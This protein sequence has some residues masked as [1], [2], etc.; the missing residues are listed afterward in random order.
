MRLITTLLLLVCAGCSASADRNAEVDAC[1]DAYESGG[2]PYDVAS[3]DDWRLG[4]EPVWTSPAGLRASRGEPDT[5]STS[6]E[7]SD[8]LATWHYR[9]SSGPALFVTV[10]DTL[11]YPTQL[12]LADG[13]LITDRGTFEPGA[14]L[15]E[16]ERAFPKSY[17]CRDWPL[18]AGWLYGD[19]ATQ[20]IVEDTAR[21][22][23]LALWFENEKLKSVGVSQYAPVSELQQAA[24]IAGDT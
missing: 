15:A 11:A 20:L 1:I 18:G 2:F 16:V 5:V 21:A 13:S 8:I 10:A 12:E 17:R 14:S 3:T 19:A 24:Q 7:P 22:A 6:I 9:Q 4:E 23:T